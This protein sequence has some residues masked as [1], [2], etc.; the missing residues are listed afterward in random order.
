MKG[1]TA[2]I[3]IISNSQTPYRMHVHQRIIRELTEVELWSVFTHETSNSPWSIQPP[4]ELRPLYW[5]SGEKSEHQDHV[6]NQGHEWRKGGSILRWIARNEVRFVVLE[7]YNDLG[8]LRILWGCRRMGIPCFVFGDNNI[9]ADH[10]SPLKAAVKRQL[11]GRIVERATGVFYCG[12]LGRDYF[13]RYG[14]EDKRMFPFPY[15]PDY[16][17]FE[18]VSDT[19]ANAV[20]QRYQVQPGRRYMI[21]SGRFAA[22]KRVDLLLKAFCEMAAQRPDWD[23]LLIGDG[24]LRQPLL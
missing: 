8:R 21:Y 3:A 18:S 4:P 22:V 15:E 23:L 16:A 1:S 12:R 13:R 6:L 19:L 7:G 2:R 20:R 10:P 9:L 5:G 11:V 24:P 14:A 17:A